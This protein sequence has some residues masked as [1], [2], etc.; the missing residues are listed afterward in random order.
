MRTIRLSVYNEP[1]WGSRVS[2]VATIGL[3]DDGTYSV[4]RVPVQTV[5]TVGLFSVLTCADE[6]AHVVLTAY[7]RLVH[8]E[9]HTT[10]GAL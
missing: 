3:A 5:R 8:S 7:L 2:R 1:V 6:A 9:Q 10:Q 4:D